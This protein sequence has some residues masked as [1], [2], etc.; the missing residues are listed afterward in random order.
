MAK[1]EDSVED[2]Q[3]T[4]ETL[5]QW[6]SVVASKRPTMNL[7]PLFESCGWTT[8]NPSCF[9]LSLFGIASVMCAVQL[10]KLKGLATVYTAPF[11]LSDEDRLFLS[12]LNSERQRQD[13]GP[14]F[15]EPLNVLGAATPLYT[16]IH[17]TYEIQSLGHVYDG[18]VVGGTFD[19]LHAG[20]RLLLAAAA[21]VSQKRLLIGVTGHTFSV[22]IISFYIVVWMLLD[23]QYLLNKQYNSQIQSLEQRIESVK[24]FVQAV[25]PS[26][27]VSIRV[28]S[29]PNAPVAAETEE[30]W[31]VIVVSKETQP[32]A[33]NI[34]VSRRRRGFAPLMV[35]VVGLVGDGGGTKLSSTD[36]RRSRSVT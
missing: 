11:P 3:A 4:C 28:L 22:E 35:V 20:H 25:R 36:I 10:A 16:P 34:N 7:V 1:G 18:G 24:L 21:F 5:R 14:V 27:E 6:Y 30:H 32:G 31:Q 17:T 23:H 2:T 9:R 13:L 29:D 15:A 26:L 33:E 12:R 19:H 8:R